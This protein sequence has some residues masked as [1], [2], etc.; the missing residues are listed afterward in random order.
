LRASHKQSKLDA[1]QE[2]EKFLDSHPIYLDTETTGTGLQDEI[3]EIAVIDHDG[4]ILLDKL[5]KPKIK[6]PKEA[7]QIH[8]I[9]NELVRN[10]PTWADIWPDL[11]SVLSNREVA[12]YNAEFDLRLM[13]QSSL[14]YGLS[15][16]SRFASEFCIMK[17]YARFY[18][19]WS[20]YHQNYTWQSQILIGQKMMH[21][22]PELS[23]IILREKTG[24]SRPR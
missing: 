19:E 23:S 3:V 20:D 16:S 13:R 21:Y 10:A 14:K 2:A 22:F 1:I 17:L 8:Q 24:Q 4:I 15:W 5:I 7:S 9:T 12:I 6:I 11:K 18:G